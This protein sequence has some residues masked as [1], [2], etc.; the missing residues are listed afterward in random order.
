M[1]FSSQLSIALAV[2]L[3]SVA[4]VRAAEVK[5][6]GVH[7]CCAQCIS[8]AKTTL[9][10]VEGVTNADANQD[11]ASITFV[12]AD[13]KAAAAG[14][15][16]LAKAGFRG[17][18]KHGDK[19][20]EFPGANVD[21]GS[22]ADTVTITGVHLCCPACYRAAEGALKSVAGVDAVKSD[23]AA[24]TIECSGKGVDMTAALEALFKAGFQASVKK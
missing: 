3:L 24:K 9:K 17:N 12:A 22:K 18:A 20:L 8:G 13:D 5:I 21:K 1:K 10:S 7:L 2:A 19:V 14:I 4:A 23:R 16:A 15:D 6:E 11:S